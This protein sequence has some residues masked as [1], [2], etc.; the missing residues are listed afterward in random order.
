MRNTSTTHIYIQFS[1]HFSLQSR[2]P[3]ATSIFISIIQINRPRTDCLFV[4][5]FGISSRFPN[6]SFCFNVWFNVCSQ[7]HKLCVDWTGANEAFTQNIAV[8]VGQRRNETYAPRF[9]HWISYISTDDWG[10]SNRVLH[11]HTQPLCLFMIGGLKAPIKSA[12][13]SANT[14][15]IN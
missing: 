14:N 2:F 5:P 13:L 3:I 1:S 9:I 15:R 4:F 10:G 12:N 6:A 8:D 7:V 11:A